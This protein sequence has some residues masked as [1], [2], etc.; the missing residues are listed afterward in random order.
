MDA[1]SKPALGDEDLEFSHPGIRT[2]GGVGPLVTNL[3]LVAWFWGQWRVVFALVVAGASL[4]VANVWLVDAL[5]RRY[6]RPSAETVRMLANVAG[7]WVRGHYTDWTPLVWTYVPYNLLWFYARDRWVLSR[8]Y[9]YLGLVASLALWQGVPPDRVLA[10]TLLGLF[11]YLFTARRMG[12]LREAVA[13]VE[14]QRQELEL[15]HQR[16]QYAHERALEQEKLS[17]LGMMAAGVAHEINNPMSFVTSN[18]SLLLKDL[19]QQPS[20]PEPLKEYVDEV[21]PETLEGVKRVNAI[22]ADLRRFARGDP[23]AYAEYDLNAEVAAALRMARG[24]L[25]H[26]QVEEQLGEVGKLL[27][28]PR[29][30]VQALVN[31][32]VNAGQ[33]TAEGGQVRVSTH[34]EPEG[35]RVEIRDTGPGL[36]PEARHHL[37]QPFFTTRPHGTGMGLGLAVAHGIITSHGGRIEVES[38]PGQGTCFTVHLPYTPPLP[39]YR[40]PAETDGS[41][42]V[43]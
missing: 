33:A 4:T 11:G 1:A 27:G 7:L 26:C 8:L 35:A 14:Q 2:V 12:L 42:V 23:E 20:L 30:I 16:L 29:Q 32:L 5:A 3:I 22:V 17:S 31:M 38:Q 21:L 24:Q 6:G 39:S 15:A 40:R 28:R 34:R 9:V 36:S 19:R 13:Q 37:F 43:A 25:S 18:L 10:F 41:P